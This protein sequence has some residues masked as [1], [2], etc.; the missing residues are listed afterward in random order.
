[1]YRKRQAKKEKPNKGMYTIHSRDK[2]VKSDE[3]FYQFVSIDPATDHF[4]FRIERRWIGGRVEGLVFVKVS[5]LSGQNSRRTIGEIGT[6]RSSTTQA[7]ATPLISYEDVTA[8]IEQYNSHYTTTHFFVIEQQLD[9]NYQCVRLSQHLITYF[10]ELSK[11]LD[12][13]P[14]V[15]EISSKAKSKCLG[16]PKG[17]NRNALKEWDVETAYNFLTKRN[18]SLS[19]KVIDSFRK[20]DDLADTVLQIEALWILFRLDLASLSGIVLDIDGEDSLRDIQQGYASNDS[21]TILIDVD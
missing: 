7:E 9:I 12:N 11:R 13:R 8:F 6:G 3:P 16:A 4:A 1:M 21:D 17:M 10:V 2:T 5:F 14:L 20:K 15:V 18:D 19:L